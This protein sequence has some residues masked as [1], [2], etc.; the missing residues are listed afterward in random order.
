MPCSSHR[1]SKSKFRQLLLSAHNSQGEGGSK[2]PCDLIKGRSKVSNSN[3]SFLRKKC[4]S[5]W[6]CMEF[7]LLI[8]CVCS[9]DTCVCIRSSPS[10]FSIMSSLTDIKM[11]V[12]R[13]HIKSE[14][15]KTCSTWW[16]EVF[17]NLKASQRKSV[18]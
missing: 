16:Q 17:W 8:I 13:A 12:Q 4:F 11:S 7:P 3:H 6:Q 18:R 5:S 10:P 15:I 2:R 14:A 1:Y 9:G